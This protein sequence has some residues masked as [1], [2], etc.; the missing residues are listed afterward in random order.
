ME[1]Y[2]GTKIIE[3]EPMCKDGKDGLFKKDMMAKLKKSFPDKR[4]KIVA[5]AGLMG[6]MFGPGG[7]LLG[8]MLG[9]VAGIVGTMTSFKSYAKKMLFGNYDPRTKKGIMGILPSMK[10]LVKKHVIFPFKK[11]FRNT[12]ENAR[13]WMTKK[14]IFPLSDAF[15][16]IKKEI[17]LVFKGIVTKVSSV[18][19]KILFRPA[20]SVFNYFFKPF[21]WIGQKMFGVISRMRIDKKKQKQTKRE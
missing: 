5:A 16:P 7:L 19:D 4:I 15:A 18:F 12:F 2:I 14:V 17:Q 10:L 9:A 8:G 21:K 1:K 3:A 11:F 6:V 13:H 20:K